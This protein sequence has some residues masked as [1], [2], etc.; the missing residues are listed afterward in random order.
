MLK[1]IR[2]SQALGAGLVV[3]GFTFIGLA[4]NWYAAVGVFLI[5]AGNNFE[6]RGG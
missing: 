5:V 3:A 2:K 4:A 6:R 1:N